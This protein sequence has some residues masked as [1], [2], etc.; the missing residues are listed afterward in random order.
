MNRRRWLPWLLSLA[1]LGAV[2]LAFYGPPVTGQDGDVSA[3][4]SYDRKLDAFAASMARGEATSQH[5]S[6]AEINAHIDEVLSRQ[7]Q[8]SGSGSPL[9]LR[10]DDVQVDLGSGDL[11][12][13]LKGRLTGAPL[14]FRIRFAE[15]G[16]F[17]HLP[18]RSVWVGRLPLVGPFGALVAGRMKPL[19][20][21]LRMERNVVPH[22]E[23]CK[24]EDDAMHLA[25]AAAQ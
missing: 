10:L 19:L 5:F 15:S 20:G 22:L 3:A 17:G 14:V 7:I 13:F 18:R 2:G 11:T 4:Q 9:T 25:V 23:T 16:S 6:E 8:T 24:I 1:A 21:G 12:V